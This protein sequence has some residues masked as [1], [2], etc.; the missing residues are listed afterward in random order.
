MENKEEKNKRKG[1]PNKGTI[2]LTF[3]NL[4]SSHVEGNLN[5]LS[6]PGISL[7]D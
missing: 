7:K 2:I 5:L 4:K 6:I 1:G 3:G